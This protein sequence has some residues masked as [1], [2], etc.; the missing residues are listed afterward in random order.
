MGL[1]D[2]LP[3]QDELAHKM[4][5]SGYISRVEKPCVRVSLDNLPE[6]IKTVPLLYCMFASPYSKIKAGAKVNCIIWKKKSGE[7]GATAEVVET[8]DDVLFAEA[9]RILAERKIK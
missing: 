8:V 2:F 7:V 5:Y 6:A 3:P 9:D 1:N 4:E